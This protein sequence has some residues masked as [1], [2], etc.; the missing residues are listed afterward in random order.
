MNT[1]TWCKKNIPDNLE[2]FGMG[3][4]IRQGINL[5][6]KE[7]QFLKLSLLDDRTI[8]AFVTTDETKAK[9][10]YEMLIFVA[11]D[12]V[13]EGS[14]L[15]YAGDKAK[16]EAAF[17]TTVGDQSVWIDGLLSRK[18]QVVPVIDKQF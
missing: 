4:I 8:H 10:G 12:I 16:M 6:H 9:E 1:C 2:V 13:K 5:K 7:G 15:Y 14:E 11:T 18:K 17:N 3:A